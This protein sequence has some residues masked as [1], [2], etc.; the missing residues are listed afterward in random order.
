MPTPPLTLPLILTLG[1]CLGAVA[2]FVWN[3]FPF[4]VVGLIVLAALLVLGILPLEEALSG[5]SN[6]ATLTVAGVLI[7]STGLERTGA[8]DMIANTF[9]RIGSS[10]ERKVVL[11]MM[12]LA[13]PASAFLN[14]TAVVAV[15]IPVVLK[16][17]R[18]QGISPSRLLI[19]LSYCSQLGGTLTL[20]GSSTNLLV[21]G[22]LVELGQPGFGFFQMTAPAALMMLGGV[23]YLMSAGRRLLPDRGAPEDEFQVPFLEFE[24]ALVVEPRSSFVGATFQQVRDEGFEA[25]KLKA[26]RR[27]GQRRELDENA[28]LQPRDLLLVEG[29]SEALKRADREGRLHFAMPRQGRE[30]RA[31][32]D[33]VVMEAVITPRSR[34]IGRKVREAAPLEQSGATIVAVQRHGRN[35]SLPAPD[36][37]LEA[38]DLVL[39][40]GTRRELNAMQRAG[41]LLLVTHVVLPRE[42]KR[43]WLATG[44]LVAVVV[45]AAAD[46]VPMAL[47]VLLGVIAMAVTGCIDPSDSYERV[48]WAVIILIGSLV[49]LGLA[50]QQTGAAQ[51]LAAL[52][53]RAAS[54]FGPYVVLATL[55][56]LTSVLTEFISNNAAAVVLTPVAVAIAGALD[57]SPVPFAMAVMMAASNS[58]MTPV[59][60]QTNTF[61]YGPG[62]YRFTD[63]TRVGTPLNLLLVALAVVFLPLFFPF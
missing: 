2:L 40:E 14:N 34:L 37:P 43:W 26:I 11:A 59:G 6:E 39:V 18:H 12:A 10:S 25:L 8:V 21:S 28:P 57:A 47:A 5:F 54:G 20:I 49:P 22:V 61:I 15:L 56:L 33:L 19:P 7:L 58:F 29:P 30:Q 53:V 41:H 46:V 38:G 31:W 50:M 16:T 60:Y 27:A 17:A 1:I 52:V 4:E 45:L 42:H 48:D 24:S 51:L 3:R 9:V 32:G 13:I 63:F 35:P 55:Y 44:I 23:V 62:G 36:R